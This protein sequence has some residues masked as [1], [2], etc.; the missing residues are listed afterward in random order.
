[1][2]KGAWRRVG[3]L[4]AP[5]PLLKLILQHPLGGRHPL[6]PGFGLGGGVQGP[7]GGLEDGLHD[8]VG[9]FAVGHG[10]V[11]GHAAVHRHGP[12]ELLHQ[13]GVQGAGP[14][15]GYFTSRWRKG[16]LLRSTVT[17]ARAS[18]MGTRASPIAAAARPG[19]QGLPEGVAQAD[20]DVLHGVVLV[21]FQVALGLDRQ[22][23]VAVGREEGQH[24]VQERD[25]GG[26]GGLA[27]AVQFQFQFHLRLFGAA[28]NLA[29]RRHG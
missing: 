14:P 11:Q 1:M 19:L 16:R 9:V 25:A 3:G 26:D 2:G 20:A 5:S 15:G 29:Q 13:L 10:D 28:V 27:P 21:H 22:V 6:G 23:E 4:V 24:V 18:S 12:P 8:V 17:W 7:A